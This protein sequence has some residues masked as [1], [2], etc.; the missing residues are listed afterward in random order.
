M[1]MGTLNRRNFQACFNE[2][3][4]IIRNQEEDGQSVTEF[5]II[6]VEIII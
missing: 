6:T 4:Q 5:E 3:K 2:G 1:D